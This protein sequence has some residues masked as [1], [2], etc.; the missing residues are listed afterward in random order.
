MCW[1][2]KNK[3]KYTYKKK[4]KSSLLST[5]N[6]PPTYK[7]CINLV[8]PKHKSS[9]TLLPIFVT[10]CQRQPSRIRG[11]RRWKST[12]ILSKIRSQSNNLSDNLIQKLSM[13]YLSCHKCLHHYTKRD[14]RRNNRLSIT[15][16][17]IYLINTILSNSNCTINKN[18]LSS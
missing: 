18:L 7:S 14:R 2:T 10:H 16:L 11:W 17:N 9:L 5:L 12:P 6:S 4:K 1:Q 3:N 15:N 8:F 13:C